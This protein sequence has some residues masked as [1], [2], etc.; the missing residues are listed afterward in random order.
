MI[1][2]FLFALNTHLR[3]EWVHVGKIKR[4]NSHGQHHGIHDHQCYHNGIH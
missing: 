1:C 2:G 4:P 3:N